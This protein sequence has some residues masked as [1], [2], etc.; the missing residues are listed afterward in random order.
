MPPPTGAKLM[1]VVGFG[2]VKPV[3]TWV[4][5]AAQDDARLTWSSDG[6]AGLQA[7]IRKRVDE[8]TKAGGGAMID[9]DAQGPSTWHSLGGV[10]MG[11]AVDRFGR[12]LGHRGLYVL[13]GA[14]IPG[15]TG[16]CNPSMT[17]A[18]LAEH[19]MAA[20]VGQDLGRVF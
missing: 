3:G 2:I 18:A 19:S 20:I 4:Y 6:D 9:T 17:I 11:A 13:D 7:L 10:P 1:T 14:R 16:A 12:V 15:S 8:F 5:D